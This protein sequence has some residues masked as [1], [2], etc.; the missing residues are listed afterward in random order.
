MLTSAVTSLLKLGPLSQYGV[1]IALVLAI[2]S[3]GS[4]AGAKVQHL[5]EAGERNALLTQI[6]ELK[7]RETAQERARA[8]SAVEYAQSLERLSAA[9]ETRWV[10]ITEMQR[11]RERSLDDFIREVQADD[12]NAPCRVTDAD[13]ARWMRHDADQ[14]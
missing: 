7:A 12:G 13:L 10:A 11:D 8:D 6:V 14:D 4:V 1:L 2:F 9:S 5:R 3:A